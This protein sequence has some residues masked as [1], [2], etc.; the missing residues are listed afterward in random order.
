MI[1]GNM[2]LNSRKS[3]I[4]SCRESSGLI[5]TYCLEECEE[6]P[7]DD[8]FSDGFGYVECWSA[9]SNCCGAEV[10]KGR[11]FLNKTSYHI[12]KKDHNDQIKKGMRYKAI[13]QKGYYIDSGK[14]EG[15]YFYRKYPC[16]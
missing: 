9:V 2:V 6:V 3:A 5:C 16:N 14:H 4:N 8:S 13:M 7:S 11:L 1:T 10:V 12:A 15:I